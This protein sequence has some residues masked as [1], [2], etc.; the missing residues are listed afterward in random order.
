MGFRDMFGCSWSV[1]RR[2]FADLERIRHVS[3][4]GLF[5]DGFPSTLREIYVS[6]S[7][8]D[9][10]ISVLSDVICEPCGDDSCGDRGDTKG[11]FAIRISH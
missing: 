5:N 4:R 2:E 10:F 6:V 1:E 8:N 9:S 3:S 11:C 7:S